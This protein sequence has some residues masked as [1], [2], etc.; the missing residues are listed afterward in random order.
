LKSR[1]SNELLYNIDTGIDLGKIKELPKRRKSL[2]PTIQFH[3]PVIGEN[4]F[5]QE[6]EEEVED[7]LAHH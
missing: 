7:M 2:C 3:K 1:H 4:I 6:V 5:A